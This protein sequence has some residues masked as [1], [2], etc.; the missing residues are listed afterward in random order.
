VPGKAL[1][2]AAVDLPWLCP[3]TESLLGLAEQPARLPALSASDPALL[4]FLLRFGPATENSSKFWITPDRFQS[5]TLPEVAA[6]YLS[7]A[8]VGWLNPISPIVQ[9][10]H[11][12]SNTAASFARRLATK[13]S[14]VSADA[15]AASARLAPLG[16]Y[17][18]AAIDPKTAGACLFE[19][20][21]RLH[22]VKTQQ[23]TWELDHDAIAR[24]LAG[25]WRFPAW[26]ATLLG[27]LN[28]PL[29]AAGE[30]VADADL[31][32]VV[33]LAVH[34]AELRSTDFALTRFADR[35]EAL[36]QLGLDETA[37]EEIFRSHADPVDAPNVTS[38]DT[39][40]RKVP[41]VHNLL[42][43]AGV[44]RR[45]NGASLVVRLEDRADQL[46]HALTEVSR[47]SGE[48]IREAKLNALVELAAGAGHEIN[49]PLAVISGN[50]QRLLR[51]EQDDERADSLR[52][53]VRQ[54]QRITTIL[55]DLMQFA[56][57]VRPDKQ[58][59]PACELLNAVREELIPFAEEKGVRF[60]LVNA[61]ADV[62]LDADP[63]QIHHAIVSVT[64]NGI[65]AAGDGGWVRLV[66]ESHPG[67]VEFIVED[68][69]PG[70][71]AEIAEHAFDPFFSGRSAGR[72]RGLGLS[73]AWRLAR[74]NGGD[75]RLETTPD[76]PTRFVVSV[77]RGSDTLLFPERMTA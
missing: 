72:G 19:P 37:C 50:A 29:R 23:A 63:K 13:H 14:R 26:L 45:K 17:A 60:E 54:T 47:I 61:R 18:V 12:F 21:F 58:T 44:A 31:F 64:R 57:P 8:P 11:T 2:R 51:T 76:G 16:W 4:A 59:V 70:L 77:P 24:R 48:V 22:P 43:M 71:D 7:A 15:A 34:E 73:T 1:G 30:V 67:S 6:A 55:R 3:N 65:E 28:L 36:K 46:H 56:R 33:Q 69:G 35:A 38:V 25:R 27:A 10:L 52:A 9:Q 20:T 41:L 53:I 49:N 5:P 39:D 66:C 74:E 40:P 75:V 32:A 68:S 62:Y 42:V